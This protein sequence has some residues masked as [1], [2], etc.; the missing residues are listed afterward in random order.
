ML[1]RL[2]KICPR[3]R[4]QEGKRRINKERLIAMTDGIIAVA[5][6]VMVLRLDIPEMVS[7]AAIR[8]RVPILVAYIIR[9]MQKILDEA[10]GIAGA[11]QEGPKFCAN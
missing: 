11:P 9:Y 10:A 4:L 2:N 1:R 5:A 3:N 6:T 7:L 8:E